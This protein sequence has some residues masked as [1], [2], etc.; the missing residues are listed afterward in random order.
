MKWYNRILRDL[1]LMIMLIL[2][3]LQVSNRATVLLM[4]ISQSSLKILVSSISRHKKL[5]SCSMLHQSKMQLSIKKKKRLLRH[6]M[7]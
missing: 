3:S 5:L 6:L 1:R 2:M 4:P 7:K